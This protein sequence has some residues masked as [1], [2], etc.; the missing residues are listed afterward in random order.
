MKKL[1]TL[2]GAGVVRGGMTG[3]ERRPLYLLALETGLRANEL[4]SLTRAA[5]DLND[6]APTVTVAAGYSKR[7][8]TDTPPLR[9]ALAAELRGH[10]ASNQP[11]ALAFSA[12]GNPTFTRMFQFDIGAAGIVYR[13]K[14]GRVADFHAL[15]HTFIS[16]VTRSGVYPKIAQSLARHSTITLTMDKYSHTLVGEQADALKGL[17]DLTGPIANETK[18]TGT[19]GRGEGNHLADHSAFSGRQQSADVDFCRLHG[20]DENTGEKAILT[21]EISSISPEISGVKIEEASPGFEPGMTVLQTVALPLG[22]EAVRE[23]ITAS[24]CYRAGPEV[25]I[26][27]PFHRTPA[28]RDLRLFPSSVIRRL[29]SSRAVTNPDTVTFPARR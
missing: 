27:R 12:P 24:K 13:N 19:D 2:T 15:R 6:S 8:R 14:D 5:F 17:P 18:K 28:A 22:D 3:S 10:L 16:N 9:P 11:A 21:P 4:R 26:P 7:R 25:S 20:C 23:S 29:H 1:L